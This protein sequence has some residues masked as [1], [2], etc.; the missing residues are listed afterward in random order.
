MDSSRVPLQRSSEPRRMY[1]DPDHVAA[2]ALATNDPNP[3]Y[4]DGRAVPPVFPVVVAFPAFQSLG[5]VPE[6]AVAGTEG[7]V[8]GAHDIRVLR[9]LEVGRWY[10]T[11]G[12][13]LSVFCNRAGMSVCIRL[14]TT[15]E[16]GHQVVEQYWS[17][18]YR[19][20]VV[21]GDRGPKP[22][23]HGF[24]GSACLHPVGSV[25]LPTS[26]DQTFRYAGV[27]GVTNPMHLNDEVARSLGWPRK[28]NQGL[29]TLAIASRAVVD[30]AAG[31]DPRRVRRLAARFGAPAFPGDSIVVSVFDAGADCPARSNF[32]FEAATDGGVALRHGWAE[33]AERSVG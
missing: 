33:V 29:C 10:Q 12:E 15:D 9:P 7:G 20:T 24:S 32:A 6:E 8:H 25:S 27:S 31:G 3:L 2:F 13:Y 23:G 11:V 17:L 19:G 30:L 28:F 21:G 1:I 22:P 16:A 14:V 4:L 26:R 18:L 5:P